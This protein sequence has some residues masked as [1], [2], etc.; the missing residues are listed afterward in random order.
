MVD[1]RRKSGRRTLGRY[2]CKWQLGALVVCGGIGVAVGA[3][4]IDVGKHGW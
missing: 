2:V 3:V 1:G 4:G